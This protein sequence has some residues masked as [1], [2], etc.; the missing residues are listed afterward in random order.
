MGMM[1]RLIRLIR[2]FGVRS[3]SVVD[4]RDNGKCMIL[5][6]RGW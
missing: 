2:S 1:L 5:F 4:W 3:M 6:E